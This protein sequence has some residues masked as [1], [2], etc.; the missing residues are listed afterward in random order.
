MFL[1]GGTAS[2]GSTLGDLWALDLVKMVW[3]R[4]RTH[5]PPAPRANHAATAVGSTLVI[6]GGGQA[7]TFYGDCHTLD[8]RR[9]TVDAPFPEEGDLLLLA[10]EAA[11]GGGGGG[12]L[13]LEGPEAAAGG[14]EGRKRVAFADQ[15]G[16]PL[17]L[18]HKEEALSRGGAG[19]HGGSSAR[20]TGSTA[21][22]ESDSGGAK[23]VLA[24]RR[25]AAEA[26]AKVF[27]P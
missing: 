26:A 14:G 11:G 1:Y 19:S 21:S 7:G 9:R 4:P 6:F 27:F 23:L 17:Q 22:T 10:G 2:D 20:S 5:A 16:A 25:S 3:S 8:I 13:M 18:T 24:G 12:L 15:D